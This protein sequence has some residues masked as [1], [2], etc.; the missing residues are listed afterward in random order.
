MS[1]SRK[2]YMSFGENTRKFKQI[3]NRR[4]RRIKLEEMGN[5][6]W[7]RKLNNPY[8]IC[9]FYFIYFTKADIEEYERLWGKAYR[10]WMK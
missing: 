7:Y 2:K 3:F 9:D 5:G 6:N 10:G 1:R 8:D 4:I